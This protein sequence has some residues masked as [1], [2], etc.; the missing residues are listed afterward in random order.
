MEAVSFSGMGEVR[1]RIRRVIMPPSQSNAA[2]IL[3]PH[4]CSVFAPTIN[5]K[6][7]KLLMAIATALSLAVRTIDVYGAT[8]KEERSTS[9][10]PVITAGEDIG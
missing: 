9:A 3:H 4:T 6:S 2:A 7:L 10:C 5:D 1:L 8:Q